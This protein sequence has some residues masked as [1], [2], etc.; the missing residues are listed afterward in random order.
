MFTIPR[1]SGPDDL[2]RSLYI[3]SSRRINISS[4]LSSF[5]HSTKE[6][7]VDIEPADHYLTVGLCVV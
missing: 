3:S 6:G 2:K 1:T 7:I 4:V 5:P